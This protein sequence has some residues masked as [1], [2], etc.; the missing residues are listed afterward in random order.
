MTAPCPVILL[1]HRLAAALAAANVAYKDLDGVR[2][3]IIE[4]D[5]AFKTA[6]ILAPN[7]REVVSPTLG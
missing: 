4:S 6:L 7:L 1:R 2:L 5:L 3:G